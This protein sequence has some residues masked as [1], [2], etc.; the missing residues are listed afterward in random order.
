MLAKKAKRVV[1]RK[2]K[3]RKD[4]IEQHGHIRIPQIVEFSGRKVISVGGSLYRQIE[5]GEYT[6]LHAV[7]DYAL[8]F[9]GEDYLKKQETLEFEKRHPALQW[10]YSYVENTQSA[11]PKQIGSGAAWLRFAYDIYTISDNAVLEEKLK[12]RLLKYKSFQTARHELW[13]AALFVTAGFR[14]DFEDETDSSEKHSEFIATDKE[15]GVKI[16]VEAKCRQRRGVMGFNDGIGKLPG[17]E[18]GIRKLIRKAYK[19]EHGLPLCVVIDTNLPPES[20]DWNLE[21]WNDEIRKTMVKLAS[22]GYDNP[23]PANLVL[24]YNDPSHYILNEEIGHEADS[25]W[26]SDFVPIKPKNEIDQFPS[27]RERLLKAQKQ[28]LRIPVDIPEI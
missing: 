5:Y 2:E 18:V 27:I 12:K 14:I 15:S 24:F 6:Y 22:D 8:H 19:K 21:Y 26:M 16:A 23:C 13:T 7:H 1:S 4:F 11:E 25:I 28:R 9:F 20:G 17:Q 10:M 3:N